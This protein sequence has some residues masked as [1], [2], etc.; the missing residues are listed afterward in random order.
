MTEIA[1]TFSIPEFLYEEGSFG[2]FVL[3]TLILGGGA[4]TLAGAPCSF[5]GACAVRTPGANNNRSPTQKMLGEIFKRLRLIC[6]VC[7]LML[8]K[9]RATEIIT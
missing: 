5:T 4:A 1:A 9:T 8:L 3:V 7:C 6:I 2:V